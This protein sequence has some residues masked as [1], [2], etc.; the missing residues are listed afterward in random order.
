MSS[1]WGPPKAKPK[2][3]ADDDEEAVATLAQ[4]HSDAAASDDFELI[5]EVEWGPRKD[6][7]G[8]DTDQELAPKPRR[9]AAAEDACGCFPPKE[10]LACLDES[11]ILY[12]CREECRSNCL[13]ASLCGN[14]R[15]QRKEFCDVEVFDAGPKGKGLR[16]SPTTKAADKGDILCE[17]TGRAIREAALNRLFRRY[18]LDRRLYILS[19]GDGVYL[20]ARQKGGL[21]R[22][23]NHSCR[24]NCIV[25][26][27]TVKSV[28]RAA[29][30]ALTT[31]QPGEELTFD[32]QWERKRG[33]ATTVC[34]CGMPE[35]R[36]TLEMPKSLEEQDLQRE[37][38]GHWEQM[39]G[40]AD[41][42]MVNRTVQIYSK[43]HKE[44][45]L[46]E[47]TGYDADK[48]LHC[49]LYRQEMNEVW[50]DLSKEDWMILN[51]KVDKEHFI[52]AKK[53]HKGRSSTPTTTTLLTTAS[54]EILGQL[55]VLSKNYLYVQTPIKDAFWSMHLIERCQRNCSVQIEAEQMARPP[56][57]P[58]NEEETEKYAL[59]DQSLDGTIWKLTITGAN[60]PKAYSILQKNVVFLEKKFAMEVLARSSTTAQA[61]LMSAAVRPLEANVAPST[62][63]A[64][65]VIFPRI[66]V[67]AV[68]R[69]LQTVRDKC[70][71]VNITFIASDSKSK[72]FSKLILEGSLLSDIETA[73][74]HLWVFLF[75]L[76]AEADAPMTPNRIY[77]NLG[78]LGGALSSEQFQLLLS[79]NTSSKAISSENRR[80]SLDAS[81]DLNCS[82]FIQSFESTYRCTVWVQSQD[83]QGRIDSSNRIVNEATPDTPRKIYFGCKPSEV[84][85]LGATIQ[86]RASELARGVKYIHLGGDR[87]YMKLMMK[88]GGRFFDFVQRVTGALVT[89]DP[90]TGDHIRIDGKLSQAT[91]QLLDERVKNMVES[92]RVS[93]ADEI[94]RLQVECYRDECVREQPWIF[95]RDWTLNAFSLEENSVSNTPT[96]GMGKLDRRTVSQCGPEIAEIVSNLALGGN[97]AGHAAI[98]LYRFVYARSEFSTQV[99]I[100]EAV[101]AC[102]FLANKAQKMVRWKRLDA[103]LQAG[104]ETFYPG[105]KFDMAS[106]EAAVLEERVLAAEKEILESVQYDVFWRDTEW[107]SLAAIGAGKMTKTHVQSAFELVFSGPVLG[108]GAEL[109]LKYGI[110]YIF[111]SAAAFLK[112]DL[113]DLLPALSLIPL[114]VWQAAQLLVENAKYGRPSNKAPSN[115]LVEG[116]K[117]RLEKYLPTIEHMCIQI[118]SKEITVSESRAPVETSAVEHRYRI[119]GQQSRQCYA[120]RGIP[121]ELVKQSIFPIIEII[122]A[123]SSCRIYVS[124]SGACDADDL[125]LDGSW[126]AI[127]IADRLFRTR[128]S[129][130]VSLPPAV[131]VSEEAWDRPNE[132]AKVCPGLLNSCDILT[133]DGWQGAIQAESTYG[134]PSSRRVGGKCC[135][136]G[137]VSEASLRKSGLRWWIPSKH[138]PSPSGSIPDMCVMRSDLAGQMDRLVEI[139]TSVAVDPDAFPMLTSRDEK[140][141]GISS[142]RFMPV[143]LQRWPPEKVAS[144]ETA[145][146]KKSNPEEPIPMGFSAAALQEMQILKQL[147]GVIPSPQGHPN[148]VVPVGIAIPGHDGN[149]VMTNESAS[150]ETDDHAHDPIFSLFR[151][152][153][154]NSEAA[155]TKKAAEDCPNIVFQ[156]TPFVLQRCLSRKVRSSENMM[157]SESILSAWF[158]DILSALVHCHAN[159]VILRTILPDQIIV[160]QSGIAKIGAMYRC[161]VL[162]MEERHKSANPRMAEKSKKKVSRKKDDDEDVSG[163][164]YAAPEILLGC[165]KHSKESD[166]WAVGCL[167]ANLLLNKPVFVGKDRTTLLTSQYKFVGTPVQEKYEEATEFPHYSKPPKRYKRGVEKAFEHILKDKAAQHQKAIDL[168]AR[169][170]HLDPQ[171]RCTAAEALGHDFI[172]DYVEKCRS[173]SFREQYV[174]DWMELK[175]RMMQATEDDRRKKAEEKARKRAAAMI[176][177][178]SKSAA[179]DNDDDLYDMDDFL[180]IS[181]PKKRKHEVK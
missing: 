66:I 163:N 91:A 112:A 83:D 118:M 32:Y 44:Y 27:W 147:H 107:I 9:K 102:I 85:R 113:G 181:S 22:Y 41:Q 67:D 59:L 81:E 13:A 86:T 173:D 37:L 141:S 80:L 150:D 103:V 177:A 29:V 98:I 129:G 57:P 106:E 176:M 87:V 139:A 63:D 23:I 53:V 104:Y 39:S 46:G 136:P 14:K 52:I 84:A 51:E 88:D 159:H 155:A 115:P 99:K 43:D 95:G 38:E 50:E 97:V 178:A 128:L 101:L 36:G 158:Y 165:P 132:Q 96:A 70:R 135:I 114:K 100:R 89:V 172:S 62:T 109:W 25:E 31:V 146:T 4:H 121:R 75:G 127:A 19:L 7:E 117:E 134:D 180:A 151:T 154:E 90:M 145:K 17:Y 2:E 55:P 156:P 18:Q 69:R 140:Q 161:T 68:K 142:E 105:A 1:R 74:E 35:C 92:E 110:E 79:S 8:Y 5:D 130:L 138:G 64:H 49:I 137:K 120:I 73:K 72:Q 6:E 160:D 26:L 54:A 48:G 166:V 153:E 179:G 171:K 76:C 131:D 20:D 143:S 94:V 10:G 148:F 125:L 122:A 42:T 3:H 111:A 33:R 78:F 45:F 61:F 21:A 47:I 77:C 28:V 93:L 175:R 149:A 11:C 24:P 123:E 16:L 174:S 108:A 168:I 82:P 164:P 30:V 34:H 12:A 162:P 126:R 133:A 65:E 169:M 40:E 119:I 167:L 152:N 15:M 124:V 144:K 170:L 56:V 116:G 60:V 71:S 157:I 58:E